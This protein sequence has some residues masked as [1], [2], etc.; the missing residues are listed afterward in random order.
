MSRRNNICSAI[1]VLLI[2]G[3]LFIS[4]LSA[5]Y[6]EFADPDEISTVFVPQV[7]LILLMALATL[8]LIR[9][10]RMPAGT[11]AAGSKPVDRQERQ[12]A[13]FRVSSALGVM[14][15][16]G[17]LQ[18]ILGFYATMVPGIFL[19]G[20]AIGCQSKRALALVSL[21]APLVV[22]LI[23]VQVA[24]LSLPAGIFFQG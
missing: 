18:D 6:T 1:T 22:W 5:R 14:L 7:L 12:R 21:I 19:I 2:A 3:L 10:L 17:F 11:R 13:V 8:L 20:L 24:E 15:A 9:A 4:T 23:I 16:M